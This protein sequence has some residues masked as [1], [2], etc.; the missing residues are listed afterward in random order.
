VGK[1]RLANS[2]ART[3]QL[4]AAGPSGPLLTSMKNLAFGVSV[5]ALAAG[6]AANARLPPPRANKVLRPMAIGRYCLVPVN[7]D[8]GM[9]AV[10]APLIDLSDWITPLKSTCS[11]L[12]ARL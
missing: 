1:P 10:T 8:G 4:C 5:P 11:G 9:A 2:P 6:L 7:G 3:A 12:P